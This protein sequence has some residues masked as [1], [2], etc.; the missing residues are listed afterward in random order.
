MPSM[1][2]WTQQDLAAV[3]IRLTQIMR[4]W[5]NYFKHAVAKHVFERLDA[6]VWWRL[7]R[8]LRELAGSPTPD[9]TGPS[10]SPH[11]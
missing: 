8:M 6:F 7:I 2:W 11:V 1:A 3:L 9:A 10:T 5:A 4:G